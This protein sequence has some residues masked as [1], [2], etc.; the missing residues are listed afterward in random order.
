[1]LLLPQQLRQL[2]EVN[3][4]PPRLV[5]GEQI[6]G[7]APADLLLEIEIA[8]PLPVLVADNN[9]ASLCSSIVQGGGKRRGVVM[10]AGVKVT[11]LTLRRRVF[12]FPP[13][14][15]ATRPWESGFLRLGTLVTAGRDNGTGIT[16]NP[17]PLRPSPHRPS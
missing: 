14:R 13:L 2:G 6:G 11:A 17:A 3:R 12:S 9:Q 8:E 16:F 10:S 15:S 4:E 1:M 5:L 7:F